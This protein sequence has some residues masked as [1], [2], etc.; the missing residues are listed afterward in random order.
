[1]QF[2][3]L[4]WSVSNTELK[5]MVTMK[6][7]QLSDGNFSEGVIYFRILGYPKTSRGWGSSRWWLSTSI[8]SVL[9]EPPYAEPHV[10]WCE[11]AEGVTPHPTRFRCPSTERK[12]PMPHLIRHTFFGLLA[13]LS[14]SAVHATDTAKKNNVGKIVSIKKGEMEMWACDTRNNANLAVIAAGSNNSAVLKDMMNKSKCIPVHA[15]ENAKVKILEQKLVPFPVGNGTYVNALKVKIIEPKISAASNN[16][17]LWTSDVLCTWSE[18]RP[19]C[20]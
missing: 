3:A 6:H 10:R 5:I 15:L 4:A 8:S 18:K 17:E 19:H 14:L 13:A 20:N 11:R 16:M 7:T 2:V 9:L 1:M 12:I